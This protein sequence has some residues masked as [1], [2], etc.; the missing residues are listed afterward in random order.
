M[1]IYA[2]KLVPQC[3]SDTMTGTIHPKLMISASDNNSFEHRLGLVGASIDDLSNALREGKVT[4]VELVAMYLNRLAYYD[5]QGLRLNSIPVLNPAVF[6][7]GAES[8]RQRARGDIKGPL[9]GIPFTVKDSYKVRGLTVAAGSPAF[10]SLIAQEDSF[11]VAALRKAGAILLGKTNMPPMAVGGVQ[12]GLYGRAESPYNPDYL[13][14]AWHSGSSSGSG[15]AVAANLCAFGLGEETVSSGRSPASNNG[16]VAYTPS[17]GLISIRGNWPLFPLR[18]TV[19]PHTRTVLDM[20]H[21]LNALVVEDPN[22]E[23]DLWRTQEVVR[24]P[25]IMDIRPPDFLELAESG[26]LAGCRLGLPKMYIGADHQSNEPIQIRPS[27]LALWKEAVKDLT[28][29]GAICIEVDLPVV[30]AYERGNLYESQMLPDGWNDLEI[31]DLVSAAWEEFLQL[32]RDP[33]C[34]TLVNIEPG[35]IHPDP[36]DDVDTRRNTKAHPGRDSI[37]YQRIVDVATHRKVPPKVFPQIPIVLQGLERARV[38]LFENWMRDEGLDAL[39]FPSNADIAPAD[40]DVDEISSAAA[41]RN[42]TVFS[43]MNHVMRHLGIPSTTVTMGVMEDTGMPVGLTFIGPAYSDQA[44]LSYA[45]DFEVK[46]QRRVEPDAAPAL[47]HET[48]PFF[49]SP[50]SGPG[51]QFMPVDQASKLPY[52]KIIAEAQLNRSG[53][54]TVKLQVMVCKEDVLQLN[55]ILRVFVDGV[56][57]QII[58]NEVLIEVHAQQ[59][60][61]A[62][63]ASSFVVAIARDPSSGL[64]VGNYL[65]VRYEK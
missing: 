14:A 20:L 12:R 8:D 39:V 36:P 29:L 40:A 47:A 19:V 54:A 25:A 53:A 52:I 22:K 31:N 57:S 48:F 1:S 30:S 43:N 34:S 27:I 49:Q 3:Q 42:G 5:R 15:V 62:R 11:A 24:L 55:F 10:A 6:E 44:L 58:G 28:A 45:Y 51:Q 21:I 56:E 33:N 61:A 16:L 7:E 26:S 17:R 50:I 35:T 32:N 9:H 13:A 60:R 63:L 2:H 18:D 4:S 37:S 64:V 23:G 41:W 59:R 38:E 65:T 46:S